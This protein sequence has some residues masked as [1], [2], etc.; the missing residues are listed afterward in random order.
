MRIPDA[1][2]T[3][4]HVDWPEHPRWWEDGLE[5]SLAP[6]TLGPVTAHITKTRENRLH[7][8]IDFGSGVAVEPFDLEIAEPLRLP[9]RLFIGWAK[10]GVRVGLAAT[11]QIVRHPWLE[12]KLAR[13]V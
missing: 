6:I 12:P 3:N 1:S 7:V 2:S 11:Q 4:I 5:H 9:E 8:Y 13:P 10:E